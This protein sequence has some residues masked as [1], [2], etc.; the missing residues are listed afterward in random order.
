MRIASLKPGAVPPLDAPATP[1]SIM[2]A[3]TALKNQAASHAIW[4][5]I[6]DF[7][8]RRHMCNGERHCRQGH[9]LRASGCQAHHR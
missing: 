4:T 1:E 6:A 8:A 7:L 3:V 9:T 2:R 5:V